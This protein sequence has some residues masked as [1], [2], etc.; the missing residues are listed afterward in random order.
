M[1]EGWGSTIG[2]H[3][4]A[5]AKLHWFSRMRENMRKTYGF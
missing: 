1:S 5:I 3:C 2:E 4:E